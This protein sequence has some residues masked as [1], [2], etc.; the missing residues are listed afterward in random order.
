MDGSG[1]SADDSTFI[2]PSCRNLS[3]RQNIRSHRQRR[4][5]DALDDGW[6]CVPAPCVL[7][8]TIDT[9][10]VIKFRGRE[11]WGGEVC[12]QGGCWVGFVFETDVQVHSSSSVSLRFSALSDRDGQQAA[13]LII[14]H[15]LIILFLRLDG[16]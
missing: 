13:L 15:F 5:S 9:N 11:G 3:A 6:A 1:R 14:H 4:A 7:L 12:V 8:A 10:R 2:I 16:V